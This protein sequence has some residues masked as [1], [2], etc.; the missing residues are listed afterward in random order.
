MKMNRIASLLIFCMTVGFCVLCTKCTKDRIEPDP[1]G[2]KPPIL[3]NGQV[4]LK[5]FVPQ[6]SIS[7]YADASIDENHID[8]LYVDLYEGNDATPIKTDK[9]FGSDLKVSG[10]SNDSI[11]TI[12]YEVDN[13]STGKLF[14][15]VYANRKDVKIISD[16][17]L[18][19][20][21]PSP[22]SF[23]FFMSGSDSVR[24]N[25][26]SYEG[27]IHL[28]RDVAKIRVNISKHSIVIPSDLAIK[29]DE[30]EIEVLNAPN[31]TSLFQGIGV[32]AGQSG[33]GYINYT[34][35]G[36]SPLKPLRNSPTF[37]ATAGGQIDSFY[38]NEN[39]L[40]SS[41]YNESNKTK[42]KV[43]I[44]TTSPTD[45]AKTAEY[46]YTLHTITNGFNLLRNYIY[47]LDIK[48]RGQSLEPVITLYITPWSDVPVDGS[49]HGTYLTVDPPEIKFDSNG[50]AIVNF[51]T[52]AQA[53]YF[54][55]NDFKTSTG[56]EI[57]AAG[58]GI[59]TEGIEGVGGGAN[60]LNPNGFKDGYILLDQQHCGSFK[61]KLNKSIFP[62]INFS[63]KICMKAGNIERWLTLSGQRIYDAHF[64]VGDSIFSLSDTY[65]KAEVYE[66][67][68]NN[69]NPGWLKISKTR[70]FSQADTFSSYNSTATPLYLHLDENLTGYSRTGSVTVTSNGIEKKLGIT[71]LPAIP[72][73]RFGYAT[74]ANPPN[75]DSVYTA[76]LYTEQLYEFPTMPKYVNTA[77]NSIINSIIPG[78][79]IYNGRKTA[80]ATSP[81]PAVF[82][83]THYNNFDYQST[84]YQAINYCAHKNRITTSIISLNNE[85]KWY[86][87]AQAQLLGLWLSYNS[88]KDISTSNFMSADIFRSST[89]NSGF[90]MDAQ[91]I[92]FRYGNIGHRPKTVKYW[93]RCVRDGESSGTYSSMVL[94]GSDPVIDFKNGMPAG[95]YIETSKGK[96]VGDEN[97]DTNKTLFRK[98]RVAKNDLSGVE[99]NID[100]CDQYSEIGVTGSWRLPTQR[101]LQA[102]WILQSEIKMNVPSFN[103]LEGDYYWSATEASATKVNGTATHAW[104]IYGSRSNAGSSGNAP[105]QPKSYRLRIR[106]VKQEL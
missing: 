97:S 93:A 31:Q 33:F 78:N 38:V 34:K 91:F 45:G 48:V 62:E 27:T 75:D 60:E 77:D 85:M 54:N 2:K 94:V 104:T 59:E 96:G 10:G 41:S 11:V 72:V 51:C 88:Y 89:N 29:Y 52:D 58:G 6:G 101:E 20:D 66:D 82:E 83:I 37:N 44:P 87:P 5:I 92:D 23:S 102:I 42:V 103:F 30:V 69:K 47:T 65:T 95:S 84:V 50:E 3:N 7:T 68:E 13:I 9:F 79:A 8:T 53:V 67:T 22:N 40:I 4:S 24:H 71:Q 76:M 21:K 15:K 43:K 100:A 105:T 106:C 56:I 55:F 74:S 57:G 81:S 14:A 90:P 49:I 26:T 19:P 1:N 32:A 63:G 35:R 18:F 12:G 99:W 61:L 28:V 16:E 64:I 98:L 39:H 80:T 73:G 36:P 46:T 86:L 70:L 17:F 25:G